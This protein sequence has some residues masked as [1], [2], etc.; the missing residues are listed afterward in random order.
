MEPV[1]KKNLL[2]SIVVFI[3]NVGDQGFEFWTQKRLEEG[4]LFGKMEFPGGKIEIGETPEEAARREVHEE[5]GLLIP[6]DLKLHLFKQQI[7]SNEKKNICLY[8][9]FG[10]FQHPTLLESG[11]MKL[12]YESKSSPYAGVIP[13]INHVFI[14]EM[15][16]YIESLVKNK[17][18]QY[19]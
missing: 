3:R 8:V 14:D 10:E 13:E 16:V 11:W 15:A 12:E 1:I 2:V 4:P 9:Y 19:L 6:K 18:W 17:S 7:Y 5:V